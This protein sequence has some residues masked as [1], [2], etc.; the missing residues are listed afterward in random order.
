MRVTAVYGSTPAFNA[1]VSALRSGQS[2]SLSP[3]QSPSPQPPTQPPTPTS[4]APPLLHSPSNSQASLVT[5]SAGGISSSVYNTLV[6]TP[7]PSTEAS[8]LTSRSTTPLSTGTPSSSAPSLPI[9]PP[10]P[11]YPKVSAKSTKKPNRL[12]FEAYVRGLGNAALHA[13]KMYGTAFVA[14]YGCHPTVQEKGIALTDAW[15]SA[16]VAFGLGQHA[17]ATYTLD[18]IKYVSP[19]Q[20][21]PWLLLTHLS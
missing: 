14:W 11:S 15:R 2:H 5:R 13:R 20:E 10:L 12:T 18:A 6:A 19:T 4:P 17:E 8:Q 9:A 7:S 21:C 1:R 3:S 16:C